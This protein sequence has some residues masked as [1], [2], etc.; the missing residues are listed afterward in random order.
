MNEYFEEN[1]R[2][3]LIL[4]A[5]LL[6]LALSLYFFLVRPVMADYKSEVENIEDLKDEIDTLEEE[7]ATIEET[8][9]E[10]DI[11]QLLLENKIP[12]KKEL[13]EYILSIQQL[14]LHSNS[15]IEEIEIAYD[16]SLT[17]DDEEETIEEEEDIEG[18]EESVEED[19]DVDYSDDEDLDEETDVEDEIDEDMGSDSLQETPSGLRTMTVSLTAFSPGFDEMLELLRLIEEMERISIVT[20]LEFEK[21]SEEDL[22]FSDNPE[23]TIAFTVKI[24]TFYYEEN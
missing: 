13:D 24:T 12:T 22:S 5:L 1:K 21:P 11:E 9:E 23:E 15:K 3:L 4:G 14:E 6:L 7:I 8:L 2:S 19:A 10:D 17:I 20:G 16:D 18:E